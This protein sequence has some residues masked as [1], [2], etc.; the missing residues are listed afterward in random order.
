MTRI[1]SAAV[2]CIYNDGDRHSPLSVSNIESETFRGETISGMSDGVTSSTVCG[3][4]D[5]DVPTPGKQKKKN[6]NK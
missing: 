5:D 1:L 2:V 4:D 6:L 3:A